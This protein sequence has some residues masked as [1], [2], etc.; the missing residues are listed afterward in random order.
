MRVLLID[1]SSEIGGAGRS[2]LELVLTLKKNYP[3]IEPIVLCSHKHGH[4]DIFKKNGIESYPTLH[5][6]FNFSRDSKTSAYLIKY[7]P[8]FVR[9]VFR[10]IYALRFIRNHIDMK[11]IDLI[12]TNAIRNDIGMILSKKY[13]I[14]HILHLREFGAKGLDYDVKYFRHNPIKYVDNHVSHYIAITSAV[15]K[16]WVNTNGIESDKISIV[17]NGIDDSDIKIRNAKEKHST[18]KI[19]MTGYFTKSK[20]QDTL[21]RA[22]TYLPADVQKYIHVD[23]IGSG[24][25]AYIDQLKQI[26]EKNKLNK[27]V[28]FLGKRNDV[29]EILSNYDVGVICSRAEAFGRVT[30]E[31]MLAGLCVIASNTGGNLE[32]IKD[33]ETGL[34]YRYGEAEDLAS[35]ITDLYN[36]KNRIV[37]L[38]EAGMRY[39]KN[40]FITQKNVEGIV[41]VYCHVLKERK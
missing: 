36:E 3:Q 38:G 41:N 26:I 32:L 35:R 8:R 10:D 5:E 19:V 21:V 33:N 14:P 24:D 12:H 30:A 9:Y 2:F 27:I 4:I 20:G 31:Y 15:K 29:H 40:N 17:Y 7:I 28:T 25:N 22:L 11:S 37:V 23:F 39:A 13:D 16:Y 18:M 34:L 6:A 1:V